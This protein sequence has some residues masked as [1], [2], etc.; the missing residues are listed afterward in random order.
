MTLHIPDAP[1][2]R[3]FSVWLAAVTT[4]VLAAAVLAMTP[5]RA[6]AAAD[7]VLLGTADS[8]GYW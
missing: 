4:V 6:N 1:L 5:T 8:F 2:R 7:A 3:T